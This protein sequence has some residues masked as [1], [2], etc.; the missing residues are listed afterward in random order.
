MRICVLGTR[1]F[2][3]VQGGIE[4]HCENLYTRL[5]KKGCDIFVMGRRPYVGQDAHDY[6]RV[7]VLSIPAPKNKYLEAIV[8]TFLGLAAAVRLKPDIVHFHAIGPSMLIP[9]ARLMNFK[10]IMTHHGDDY[11]RKKWGFLAQC[12]LRAGEYLG[13]QWAHQIIAVSA[14]TADRLRKRRPQDTHHIPNGI[15]LSPPETKNDAVVQF[16]L[17][18]NR[19]VLGVGRLVP[20][21]GFHDLLDAFLEFSRDPR[22]SEWKLIIAG[23]ADHDDD[24]SRGLRARIAAN[25]RIIM[26]GIVQGAQLRQLYA[27]AGIFVLP[28]YHEGLSISLLEALASGCSCL[29]SDIEANRISLIEKDRFFQPGNSQSLGDKLAAYAGS[30]PSAS[31]KN[32]IRELLLRDYDWDRIAEETHAVYGSVLEQPKAVRMDLK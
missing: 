30:R 29:V 26:P 22:F 18:A 11:R 5:A 14:A 10:V 28:S 2:P 7:R 4:S 27:H 32:Q 20:E 13:V 12:A 1:G 17:S 9:L 23:G 6:G 25:D 21:K 31:Q 3:G 15:E 19:Y 16:G 8:H 24:Y